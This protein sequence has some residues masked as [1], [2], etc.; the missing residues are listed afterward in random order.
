MLLIF[1]DIKLFL[2]FRNVYFFF[3]LRLS[4]STN[5]LFSLF[6]L[7]LFFNI[8]FIISDIGFDLIFFL[9]LLVR[10]CFLQFNSIF[11]VLAI[12]QSF[13]LSWGGFRCFFRFN[14]LISV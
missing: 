7:L 4:F 9:A 8:K 12:S 6:H 2:R 5:F 1:V 11:F 13:I 10:I 14:Y 3:L